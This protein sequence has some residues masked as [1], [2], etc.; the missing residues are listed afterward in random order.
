MHQHSSYHDYIDKYVRIKSL[1]LSLLLSM[2]IV[3][4]IFSLAL[5]INFQ[6]I[7]SINEMI[8]AIADE[9]LTKPDEASIPD[10]LALQLKRNYPPIYDVTVTATHPDQSERFH[11]VIEYSKLG[12]ELNL[13]IQSDKTVK[14]GLKNNCVMTW[15]QKSLL[16]DIY[17]PNSP[18]ETSIGMSHRLSFLLSSSSKGFKFSNSGGIYFNQDGVIKVLAMLIF[19]WPSLFILMRLYFKNRVPNSKHKKFSN[20]YLSKM[21]SQKSISIKFQPV[22]NITNNR[23]TSL[24]CLCR[25][26]NNDRAPE[27][28]Q[29]L[30]SSMCFKLLVFSLNTIQQYNN[31]GIYLRSNTY[32]INVLP[33]TIIEYVTHNIWKQHA[34]MNNLNII[35]EISESKLTNNVRS[36]LNEAIL[37][38]KK[39]GFRF[40]ID[41]FGS[42]QASIYDVLTLPIDYI[43]IDRSIVE[44]VTLKKNHDFLKS[45]THFCRNNKIGIVAEGVSK[46]IHR[47]TLCKIGIIFQQGFLHGKAQPLSVLFKEDK[48]QDFYTLPFT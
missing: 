3:I 47:D 26:N 31:K 13:I 37:Q 24:E 43:K 45:V 33:E 15:M 40:M 16:F 34:S 28:I 10:E 38:L 7:S 14:I 39:I 41:R 2:T 35:I 4:S 23:L 12:I 42:D 29:H 1:S 30:D 48:R 19:L 44:G 9:I 25:V 27:C 46:E 8:S 6:R 22:I 32:S 18:L 11:F 21:I 20:L 17:L 5:I 36:A